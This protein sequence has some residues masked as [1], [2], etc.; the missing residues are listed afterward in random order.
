MT[1]KI[2]TL[3]FCTI[4]FAKIGHSQN[5]KQTDSIQSPKLVLTFPV[6]D[7][8][9]IRYQ[10]L[11]DPSMQQSLALSTDFYSTGNYFIKKVFAFKSKKGLENKIS[12]YA[13]E[14]LSL[15]LFNALA[16]NAP[17]GTTWLHEEFHRNSMTIQNVKSYNDVYDFKYIFNPTEAPSVSHVSDEDLN[18]FKQ[19]SPTN[20]VRLKSAGVEAETLLPIALQNNNFY[21]NL[22]LPNTITYLLS[23]IGPYLYMK[24]STQPSDR[25]EDIN[26]ERDYNKDISKR[27]FAGADFN[28]WIYDL[29]RPT[30]T[31]NSRGVHPSGN[32]IKR[33]IWYSDLTQDEVS[34][35]NKM[36]NR[37]LLNL[38]SPMNFFVNSIR[39]N[40]NLRAN[41]G[42]QH[43]LTSFGDDTGLRVLLNYKNTNLYFA[44]HGFQNKANYFPAIEAQIIDHPIKLQNKTIL[45]SLQT[46]LG[47]QPKGQ[48]FT[49][50]QQQFIGYL[51]LKMEYPITKNF[52]TYL[53]I[54]GKT[55][56]WIAGNPF[57]NSN[58]GLQLG[59]AA[60]FYQPKAH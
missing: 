60:K 54:S 39:L 35:L 27:D 45:T 59:I 23:N 34:Y 51:N 11:A 40:N 5:N 20:F 44:Y 43:F 6:I 49:T 42:F 25:T 24:S 47:T 19:Q 13:G 22:E 33:Y 4:C 7:A 50:D 52:Y 38:I 28:A 32:G 41:F 48:S 8:P 46:I 26:Y 58:I 57:L 29:N 36:T 14:V 55:E 3:L 16:Y 18:R 2:K 56:G 9:F 30:E 53:N 37:Q 1:G 17:F 31:Y 10:T 12:G 21:Y 15:T